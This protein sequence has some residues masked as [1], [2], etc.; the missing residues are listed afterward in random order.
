MN[1][2][3]NKN[4]SEF[5]TFMLDNGL[6]A[7]GVTEIREVLQYSGVTKVPGTSRFLKGIINL[8]GSVV[9]VA[10]LRVRFDMPEADT[11]TNTSVIVTE[12]NSESGTIVAGILVDSVLE[13]TE[14][15]TDDI[16]PVPTIGTKIDSDFIEGMGN[17]E[18]EFII[19]LK[20][21]KIFS[22][23]EINAVMGKNRKEKVLF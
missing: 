10:D 9:P 6:Y 8:R 19:I 22:N 11:G 3:N 13:V 15:S 21:D 18:G 17:K 5:L 1:M 14:L 23:V 16:S 20:I 2:E 12:V 4:S 7:V